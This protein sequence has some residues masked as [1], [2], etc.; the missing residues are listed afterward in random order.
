MLILLIILL[1]AAAA[2][3]VLWQALE[4]AVGVALGLFLFVALLAVAGYLMIRYRLRKFRREW[5]GERD[6]RRQMPY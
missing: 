4:I 1:I 3:G 5:Y 2:A 6:R